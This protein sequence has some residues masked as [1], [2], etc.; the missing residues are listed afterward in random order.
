LKPFAPILERV[1][2]ALGELAPDPKRGHDADIGHKPG[3]PG[4][5]RAYGLD[6]YLRKTRAGTPLG[7]ALPS[8]LGRDILEVGCGQ[9]GI[10]YYLASIGA[11]RVVGIDVNE[12]AL[13]AAVELGES[14]DARVRGAVEFRLMD[15][16]K[17]DFGDETFDVVYAENVFEHL[18]EPAATFAEAFRVLRPG[19]VLLVPIFSSIRSKHGLHLKRGL[20]VPWA[21]LVFSEQVIVGAVARRA[22]RRPELLVSYPGLANDPKSVRDL[23]RH[24]DLN[25]ITHADF[26]KMAAEAGFMV[27]RFE[28]YPTRLGG[29]LRALLRLRDHGRVLE[30]LSTGAGA[31]LG[32]PLGS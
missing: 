12:R 8:L 20:K 30:V 11:R 32:K 2:Y 6:Q 24:R 21:N 14:F 18:P 29:L 27:E 19:G 10:S 22:K 1:L 15:A 4:Y 23:R 31:V 28:V 16:K 7:R 3:D 5:Q 17:L 25:Y 13:A 9:G 26:L